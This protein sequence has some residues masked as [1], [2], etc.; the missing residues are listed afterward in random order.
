MSELETISMWHEY[1]ANGGRADFEVFYAHTR[2]NQTLLVKVSK[3][4]NILR[5]E[6]AQA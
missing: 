5:G 3:W 6:K 4:A 2:E 1:S